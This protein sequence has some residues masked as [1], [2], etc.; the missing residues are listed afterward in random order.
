[1][2]YLAHFDIMTMSISIIMLMLIISV[3]SSPPPV[4]DKDSAQKVKCEPQLPNHILKR[5]DI[6]EL[7]QQVLDPR[8][9]WPHEVHSIEKHYYGTAEFYI[10]LVA[11]Q[12]TPTS[13]L[14]KDIIE[15]AMKDITDKCCDKDQVVA[16]RCPHP[17]GFL[18]FH[19]YKI[20][21]KYAGLTGGEC[22]KPD[23]KAIVL[24]TD[25]DKL[26]HQIF[27][28]TQ[29]TS[30]E[31]HPFEK[32][33]GTAK[34][35]IQVE[36]DAQSKQKAQTTGSLNKPLVKSA[37]QEMVHACCSTGKLVQS[38]CPSP[39]GFIHFQNVKIGFTHS[40]QQKPKSS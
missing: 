23:G 8:S 6:D 19:N 36:D 4:K 17:G 24:K 25:I 22:E 21:I 32:T 39:G 34:F 29:E 3:R 2:A 10:Q 15:S 5:G 30:H 14:V 13:I 37:I 31:V 28:D 26:C 35:Y 18:L 40:G 12:K 16:G 33:L 11:T 9:T 27:D 38:Q 7:H 20:G 1:M